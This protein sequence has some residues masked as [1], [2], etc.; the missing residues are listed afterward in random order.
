[1]KDSVLLTLTLAF[2][3]CF[4]AQ[5]TASNEAREVK[6][7]LVFFDFFDD[8]IDLSINGNSVL[9]G[10][11]TV[12]K[13]NETTGLSY[14]KYFMLKKCNHFKIKSNNLDIRRKICLS[15]KTKLIYIRGTVKPPHIWL[16]NSG[17]VNLD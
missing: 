7:G 3:F 12:E 13:Q 6:I 17:I 1:M 10:P 4:Y 2:S 11:I 15:P 14:V 9:S 16:S 5:P 8:K